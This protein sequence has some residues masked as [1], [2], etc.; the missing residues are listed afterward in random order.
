MVT[1]DD[2]FHNHY[3]ID[4]VA[5]DQP[6]CLIYRATDR[7]TL[8]PVLIAELPH[9][10]EASLQGTQLLARE[11]AAV[12]D[13][14]LLPLYEHF[15]DSLT[16]YMIVGDP[17]G[18]ELERTLP[19]SLPAASFTLRQANRLLSI[20]DALHNHQ[21][22][23][24]IGDLH[25]TDLWASPEGDLSLAPFA[26]LR[27]T[28]AGILP[29]RAPELESSA[30]EPT[31]ASDLYALGAV[32]YHLLTG[33][34]PPTAAQRLAGT[35]LNAPRSLDSQIAPLLE[36][37]IL[38][39]LALQ[40]SDRYQTA[41]EMRQALELVRLMHDAD[42]AG[43]TPPPAS[44]P[45]AIVAQPV[46]T[47]FP[48]YDAAYQAAT[49]ADLLPAEHPQEEAAPDDAEDRAALDTS[50]NEPFQANTCLIVTLV[51]LCVMAMGICLIAGFFFLAGPGRSFLIEEAPWDS[52]IV[53]C[54]WLLAC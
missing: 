30:G 48:A 45:P 2:T 10:D 31:P 28:R 25:T 34:S 5:D 33:W 42:A 9:E 13:P 24:L 41:R 35:P 53:S 15:A 6:E 29:Y 44:M 7:R 17:G 21:R 36:Q 12:Q 20:F 38:R 27:P 43:D 22:T 39:A 32:L 52:L 4:Y 47:L 51:V 11:V 40:R 49:P 18:Y 8:Q 3:Q 16:Y 23:L 50:A 37:V 14:A 54:W 46:E 19:H 26:L 1:P